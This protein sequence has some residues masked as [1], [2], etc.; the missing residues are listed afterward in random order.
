MAVNDDDLVMADEELIEAINH[1]WRLYRDGVPL[2]TK[3][4]LRDAAK[5]I[6]RKEKKIRLTGLDGKQYNFSGH[7]TFGSGL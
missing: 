6:E 4:S 2:L 1:V 7:C 5:Q 3:D